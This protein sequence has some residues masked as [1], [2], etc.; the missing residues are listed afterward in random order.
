VRG[1]EAKDCARAGVVGWGECV[2]EQLDCVKAAAAI[3]QYPAASIQQ[4]S[5]ANVHSGGDFPLVR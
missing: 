2:A 1:G 3:S 4:V 5:K